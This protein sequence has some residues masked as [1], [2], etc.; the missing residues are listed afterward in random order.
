LIP[1][2]PEAT[3][4]AAASSVRLSVQQLPD[5]LDGEVLAFVIVLFFLVLFMMLT[6]ARWRVHRR[7]SLPGL[8][9]VQ[10]WDR[11]VNA[12]AIT[13]ASDV[14][15]TRR[16]DS[17]VRIVARVPGTEWAEIAAAAAIQQGSAV[18]QAVRTTPT[19]VV[20][21]TVAD[22]LVAA[23]IVPFADLRA[24]RCTRLRRSQFRLLGAVTLSA[25]VAA[26]IISSM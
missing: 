1:A 3:V 16:A 26:S 11:L 20:S 8:R 10:A 18:L 24:I 9:E 22:R 17:E 12:R 15:A 5:R 4:P 13:P 6:A 14:I 2:A 19:T 7:L 21:S 23:T 25:A